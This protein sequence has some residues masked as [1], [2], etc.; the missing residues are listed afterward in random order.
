MMG[1]G[2]MMEFGVM[3]GFG[4]MMEFRVMMEF[5]V[6]MEFGVMMGFG[7]GHSRAGVQC[8]APSAGGDG[9]LDD[10]PPG[11]LTPDP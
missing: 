11:G 9:F 6:M 2:V 1:F 4:I 3:M 10:A 7:V 8:L 5:V